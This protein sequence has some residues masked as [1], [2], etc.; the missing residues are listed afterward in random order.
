MYFSPTL[1]AST[2]GAASHAFEAGSVAHELELFALLAGIAFVA[3]LPSDLNRR[4]GQGF[5]LQFDFVRD[6]DMA[7]PR[8]LSVAAK[9]ILAA[10]REEFGA[11]GLGLERG[12]VRGLAVR[13]FRILFVFFDGIHAEVFWGDLG[14][15]IAV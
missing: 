6:A 13:A 14:Q 8:S 9:T 5:P 7:G 10:S 12:R 1:R 3:F 11:D 2:G 4:E 15:V